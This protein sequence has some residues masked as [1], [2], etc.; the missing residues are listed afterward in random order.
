MGQVFFRSG[1]GAGDTYALLMCG[2]ML[3]QHKHFDNNHFAIFKKGFLALD[4]GSR[5][6]SLHTQ[7]YYPRTIAHNCILI[8]M[9]GEQLPVYVD[10]GAGGGQRWGAPAP[11]EE[12]RPV[13][14][15]GGQYKL[16][17]SEVVAFET[18]DEYSYAAGD[19]TESYSPKKCKLALRQFV[20]LNP[21]TL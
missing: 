18:K 4:T 2:G 16:L 11:E 8:N 12:D 20:F 17:G 21:I 5:P 1:S 14:N 7:N 13:P 9:P 6:H 15:D 10:V 3:E 19:A